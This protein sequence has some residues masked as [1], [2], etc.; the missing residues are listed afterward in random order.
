MSAAATS[1]SANTSTN[2][3]DEGQPSPYFTIEEY[4]I[5]D[6]NLKGIYF[7]I[8]ELV[9]QLLIYKNLDSNGT[10]KKRNN[11]IEKKVDCSIINIASCYNTIPSSQSNAY[12]FSQ[13]G[14]D[15]FTSSR[16]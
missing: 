8:R 10:I 6:T 1:T 14:V 2:S 5:T 4:G 12:A 3:H 9:M 15:P 11:N 13:S 7:C 16:S